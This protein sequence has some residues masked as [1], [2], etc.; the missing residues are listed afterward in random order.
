DLALR[1]VEPL[2]ALGLDALRGGERRL[3][4]TL[5]LGRGGQLELRAIGTAADRGELGRAVLERVGATQER[6]AA[7]DRA[8]LGLRRGA[9]AARREDREPARE[10][11]RERR[12]ARRE[13]ERHAARRVLGVC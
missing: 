8:L 7:R 2:Q 6:A 3:D 11:P 13:P 12:R 9:H 10:Q 4:L 5:S 1:L